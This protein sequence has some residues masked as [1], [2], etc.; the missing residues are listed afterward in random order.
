MSRSDPP[1]AKKA[2]DVYFPPEAIND[3]PV[4]MQ[5]SKKHSIVYLVTKYGEGVKFLV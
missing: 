4:T 2:V 1:F 3:F 5:V